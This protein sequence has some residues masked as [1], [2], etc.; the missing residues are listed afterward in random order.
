VYVVG[1]STFT[2]TGGIIYGA[3]AGANSNT[4]KING[5]VQTNKGA[6]VWTGDTTHRRE[7]TVGAGQNLSKSGSTYTGQW[8]D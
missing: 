3:S 2:K 7:T 6:A 5:V 8:T 1:N 4:V